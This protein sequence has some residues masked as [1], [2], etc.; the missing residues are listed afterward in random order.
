[1]YFTRVYFDAYTVILTFNKLLTGCWRRDVCDMRHATHGTAL[2][3][4][5]VE[6]IL[7]INLNYGS[8]LKHAYF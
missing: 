4:S 5:H 8:F 3:Q 6:I 1:M 7:K 2:T